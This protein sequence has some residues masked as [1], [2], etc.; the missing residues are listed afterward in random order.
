MFNT[1]KALALVLC[2]TLAV[3]LALTA[4]CGGKSEP[5]KPTAAPA[6]DKPRTTTVKAPPKPTKAAMRPAATACGEGRED[7]CQLR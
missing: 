6:A 7:M 2:L 4:G 3:A 1:K 5:A